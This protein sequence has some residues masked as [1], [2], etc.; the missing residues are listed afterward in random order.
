MFFFIDSLSFF[1]FMQASHLKLSWWY[2]HF[3]QDF[4][5]KLKIQ[6]NVDRSDDNRQKETN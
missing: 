2:A 6:C 3:L 1:I 4:L 5:W